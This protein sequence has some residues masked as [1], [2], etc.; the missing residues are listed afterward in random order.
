MHCGPG[1]TVEADRGP[2]GV[3]EK[4]AH[5]PSTRA[6]VAALAGIAAAWLA[7]GSTGLLAHPFR[8]GLAWVALAVS[9]VAA[10]PPRQ[11]W[12]ERLILLAA[13]VVAVGMMLPAM[14][15]YNVLAACLVLA[16]LSRAN[17]GVDQRALLLAALGAAV[18]GVYLLART[19]IPTVWSTA[20]ALGRA[21]GRIGATVSGRPLWIGAT[22]AGLDFLVL[23]AGLYAGWLAWT[24]PPR[25]GRAVYAGMAILGGH[26]AYLV[27]L[28]YSMDLYAALPPAP[29]PPE[30]RDYIPPPWSWSDAAR[31]LLPWNVRLLAGAIQLAVAAMMFRWAAW[32]PAANASP[33]QS[34]TSE[35]RPGQPAA[36][37]GERR[38]RHKD[39]ETSGERR[40]TERPGNPVASAP[41]RRKALTWAP[42]V[43]AAVVPL[44]ITLAPGESNLAGKKIVAYNQGYLDWERPVHDRYGQA[45]AGMYGMLPEFVASLGGQLDASDELVPQDLDGADVLLSI[46]PVGPWPEDRLQRVREFVRAGGSLLVLAGTPV[47][48][49]LRSVPGEWA[50]SYNE[51]LGHV[52]EPAGG[53]EVRFDSAVSATWRWQDSYAALAHPAVSGIDDGQNRFGMASGPSIRVRWP[54]RPLLAGRWGWSDPGID[55]AM[56]RV[57]QY[58]AGEKLGDLV[59]AA[60]QRVGRG[61]VV[62]VSDAFGFTNE[63]N[64]DSYVFTGRMLAYLAGGAGNPQ[65]TWRQLL[66]LLGCM[67]LVGLMAWPP[68]PTRLA[69]AAVV[70][71]MVLA[72]SRTF[73]CVS[74]RVLPDGR[75]HSPHNDVAYI[76]ASHMEAYGDSGW[77]F[78]GV[79]GLALTLMRNGFQAFLLP[80]LT[81]ERLDRAGMLVFIAPA[82][83]FSRAERAAV[84]RFVEGGGI[85]I[86]TVGA[87]RVGP[88]EPLL[89]EFNL[90]VPPIPIPAHQ[91]VRESAPMG[92]F[93]TLY[94]PAGADYDAGV[95]IYH[96]WPVECAPTDELFRG[97]DNLPIVALRDVGR[98]KVVLVG[99]TAFAM[100]KNLEYTGGEPFSGRYDNAHFWRWL[101]GSLTKQE[102]WL[103]P[104]AEEP[105]VEPASGEDQPT[106]ENVSGQ[107][108]DTGAED[109]SAATK[110]TGPSE[111]RNLPGADLGPLRTDPFGGIPIDEVA[112]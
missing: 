66:G 44:L 4:T 103:P 33:E 102:P 56:T 36:T 51:L 87:D 10:W 35:D 7:A 45:S 81:S 89:E 18:L 75:Q 94:R 96:G 9:L 32:L 41:W 8:H 74:M 78:E 37:P 1:T 108:E 55:S 11:T 15:V 25:L 95:R 68:C 111:E 54:A 64:V 100:N 84:R 107:T 17:R 22:F 112:P 26:L 40:E 59:L 79:A 30:F 65:A 42:V 110:M 67:A 70:L 76:D 57:F 2:S 105:K 53:I 46:H 48:T 47:R 21:S 24:G 43:L 50:S 69:G 72:G 16:M 90:R 109:D 28:S 34:P 88:V 29:P 71:A 85:F 101:I 93:R 91:N 99:D 104:S 13:L 58:D 31:S 77:G 98:G 39:Q 63:G 61:T 27:V 106:P 14:P 12:L 73:T 38:K 92:H 83:P 82:R 49:N 23:M 52:L 80:A 5:G 20:D 86:C 6:V 3:D 60:E 97:F 62:V 19:S